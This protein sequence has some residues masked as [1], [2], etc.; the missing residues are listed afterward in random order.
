MKKIRLIR[1][2]EVLVLAPFD[3]DSPLYGHFL[4]LL[5]MAGVPKC[6]QDSQLDLVGHPYDGCGGAQLLLLNPHP[7]YNTFPSTED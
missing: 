5:Y 1:V 4:K 7:S 3:I 6:S 2:W